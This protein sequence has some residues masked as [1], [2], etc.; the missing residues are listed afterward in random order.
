MTIEEES[1]NWTKEEL[2]HELL[3]LL[4]HWNRWEKFLEKEL[5]VVTYFDLCKS[6]AL[7]GSEELLG[8]LNMTEDEIEE[9]R[10]SMGETEKELS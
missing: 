5:G 4:D 1:R 10:H 8:S 6:F 3:S 7:Q 2:R 9:F